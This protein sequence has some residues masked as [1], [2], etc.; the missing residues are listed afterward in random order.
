MRR[1]WHLMLSL[2]LPALIAFVEGRAWRS[3][4]SRPT[5]KGS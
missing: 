4:A 1:R 2:V 5:V 3:G